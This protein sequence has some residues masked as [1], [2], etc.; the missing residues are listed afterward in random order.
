M[1]TMAI[2]IIGIVLLLQLFNLQ[3]VHGEEYYNR[4]SRRLTREMT[5]QAAR[6]NILDSDGNILAGT[7]ARHRVVMHRSRIETSVLNN[8]I[9]NVIQILEHNED[10]VRDN[11]PISVNPIQFTWQEARLTRWKNTHNIDEDATAE[12]IFEMFKERYEITQ[13]DIEDARRIIGVR[14]GMAREGFGTRR[15]YVLAENISIES[16]AKLEEQN[17]ILP[18]VSIETSAVRRYHEGSLGSHILGYIGPITEEELQRHPEYGVNDFI[19]KTG[20]EFVFESFLRGENGRM[21]TDM[22]VDGTLTGEYIT[23]A[24]VAGHDV[25]LTINANLQRAAE[26]ALANNIDKINAGGFGRVW[27]ATAGSVVVLDV[28]TGEV[29]AM[30]SYPDFEPGL[31]IDGISTQ[32]W[33]EYNDQER[34]NLINRSIQSAYAPGSIYKMAPGIAAL[35][36]G[37]VTVNERIFC[38]GVFPRGH[39]PRCWIYPVRGHGHGW[40]NMEQAIKYSCNVYFYEIGSRMGIDIIEDYTS[41]FGMGRRTNIEL[42]GELRRNYSRKNIIRQTRTNMALW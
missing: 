42:P 20:I 30:A 33:N 15:G 31:F 11:F 39:N 23:E 17:A 2:Y 24:A 16:V 3:V 10:R 21:Q 6:G 8:T 9:L 26:T 25:V 36:T 14:Y 4:S 1:L 32:M 27:R 37:H 13:E 18:G 7:E 19:G 12:E 40:L 28:R 29:L 5:I 22:S 38:G 34:R 41:R 35:N